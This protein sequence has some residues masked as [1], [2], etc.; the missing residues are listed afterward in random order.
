[1]IGSVD[2]EGSEFLGS[3]ASE[4]EALD[5]ARFAADQDIF[6]DYSCFDSVYVV[7]HALGQTLSSFSE[8][9]SSVWT[10]VK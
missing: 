9:C 5:A 8:E 3:Y 10:E 2:Y 4:A 1:V 7:E 6:S